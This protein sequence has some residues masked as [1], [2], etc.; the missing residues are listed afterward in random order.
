[1]RT[2][3]SGHRCPLSTTEAIHVSPGASEAEA[4]F[5]FTPSFIFR[6]E[7][8]TVVTCGHSPYTDVANLMFAEHHMIFFLLLG[9]YNVVLLLAAADKASIFILASFSHIK[10][11]AEAFPDA[12]EG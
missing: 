12:A 11:I 1:M 4:S 3:S 10:M 9:S 7:C 6:T 5:N 8:G 2:Y